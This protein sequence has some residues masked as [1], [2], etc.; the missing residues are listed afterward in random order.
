MQSI[1]DNE[2]KNVKLRCPITLLDKET[3]EAINKY[4]LCMHLNAIRKMH[5]YTQEEL[6]A[7]SGVSIGTV[8]R[9]ET[10]KEITLGSLIKLANSCGYELIL[11]KR[12]DGQDPY[13]GPTLDDRA[14]YENPPIR[15]GFKDPEFVQEMMLD[16]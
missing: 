2:I 14:F 8:S 16:D 9:I 15:N 3:D 1:V 11:K 13:Y 5:H 10:G 6:S 4:C 7:I 12:L